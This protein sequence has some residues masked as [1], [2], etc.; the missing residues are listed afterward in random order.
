MDVNP[1]LLQFP[2]LYLLTPHRPPR[3]TL[4][5]YTTLFR[6]AK[7]VPELEAADKLWDETFAAMRKPGDKIGRHTSE[8]QSR[9]D[10]VCRLL[11]E[12]KKPDHHTHHPAPHSPK[13]CQVGSSP[14]RQHNCYF[15][16]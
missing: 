7:G 13:P 1:L 3:N 14:T 4:F 11:L 12:K 5:P 9:F 6:S 2:H 10:L 8:L 15:P 16:C